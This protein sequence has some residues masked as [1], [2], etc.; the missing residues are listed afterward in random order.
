MPSKG[1]ERVKINYRKTIQRISGPISE[2]AVY[3][4]LQTG[5]SSAEVKT[6]I[7]TSTLI[8]SRYA[9]QI[10]VGRGKVSGHVGYTANYAAAVHEASG[11]LKGEPRI[12]GNGNYWDPE[13]DPQFLSK[14]FED[15]KSVIPSLLKRSYKNA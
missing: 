2:S 11:V 8:N 12:N 4:V 14:G 10:S 9:P 3:A 13:A 7:D 5:A 1:I 15:I 6:P